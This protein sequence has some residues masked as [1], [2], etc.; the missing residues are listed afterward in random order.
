MSLRKFK[1]END[2]AITECTP[3]D[4]WV[5]TDDIK[6][7]LNHWLEYYENINKEQPLTEDSTETEEH[8]Y[9]QNKGAISAIRILIKE[10]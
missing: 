1:I 4:K 2:K 7:L 5:D 6:A 9:Y 10:I 8:M 3:F